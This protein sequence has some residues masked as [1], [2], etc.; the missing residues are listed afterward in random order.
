[1]PRRPPPP[2]RLVTEF[3][4]LGA[5]PQLHANHP[6]LQKR[7]LFDYLHQPCRDRHLSARGSLLQFP[8]PHSRA[9]KMLFERIDVKMTGHMGQT[10]LSWAPRKCD[11]G[12]TKILSAQAVNPKRADLSSCPALS[13][14]FRNQHLRSR[15]CYKQYHRTIWHPH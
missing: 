1:M 5:S 8:Y 10:A 3:F 9:S 6:P 12:T 15:S 7:V 13:L 4:H 14:A 11:E 2:T